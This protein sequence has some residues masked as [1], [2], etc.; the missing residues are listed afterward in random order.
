MPTLNPKLRRVLV[1]AY[2]PCAGFAGSCHDMRW[3]P[4]TG[5]VPRGFCGA[6]GSLDD[7]GLVLVVAEPGDPHPNESHPRDGAAAI[8]SAYAYAYSCF[9]DE[10]DLFHRNIRHILKLCW[11]DSDCDEQLRR[12]WITESVL[13]SAKKEGGSVPAEVSKAC[14]T[15]YLEKQLR[16]FPNAVVAALGRKA[17]N[18]LAGLP[19]IVAGSAAPPGCNRREVRDSWQPIANAVSARVH[20]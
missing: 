20:T 3:D 7:V 13:C 16:L 11:P 15:R 6:S 8:D 4:N 9:R 14:R 12:T 18:R 2:A 19:V 17:A 10:K 5:Y 1:D